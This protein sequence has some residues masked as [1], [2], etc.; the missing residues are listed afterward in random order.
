MSSTVGGLQI[1]MKA[2]LQD[3]RMMSKSDWRVVPL[4]WNEKMNKPARKLRIAYYE[5][6]DIFPLTPG[7]KRGLKVSFLLSKYRYSK[8]IMQEVIELLKADGHEIIKWNPIDFFKAYK[9]FADFLVADKGYYFNKS[10]KYEEI[11]TS[12]E[13]NNMIFKTPVFIRCDF[14]V[15]LKS[16]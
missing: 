13:L 7:V 4:D 9:L 2:I 16:I 14:F 1:G 15:K 12:I 10:M 11:D 3:A 6:D 8:T 5:E